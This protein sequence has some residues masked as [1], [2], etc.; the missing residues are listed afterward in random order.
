MRVR[1]YFA[2][3]GWTLHFSELSSFAAVKE[4]F[5]VHVLAGL[6]V[7]G[8]HEHPSA[9]VAKEKIY[10]IKSAH[11]RKDPIVIV[12]TADDDSSA[13]YSK[14]ADGKAAILDYANLNYLD[15]LDM[16]KLVNAPVI[17]A[18][19][20]ALGAVEKSAI[21]CRHLS[22]EQKAAG[23]VEAA[24]RWAERAVELDPGDAAAH[25][26]LSGLQLEANDLDGAERSANRAWTLE[27]Q[28]AVHIQR[29]SLLALK[30]G[31]E[32][33]SLR[34]AQEAVATGQAYAGTHHHLAYLYMKKKDYAAAEAA[35][36]QA[37]LLGQGETLYT[38]RLAEIRGFMNSASGET[39]K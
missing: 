35:Q 9:R 12:V 11:P 13:F 5:Y 2:D 4:P 6:H 34:L 22:R 31:R 19:A 27:P 21:L 30:R 29:L 39:A 20:W 17:P 16:A 18:S 28:K 32:E 24:L 37:V 15:F 7:R 33:E 1:A 23:N 26:H 8:L 10:N 36:Q 14:A 38:Q 3:H 25:H